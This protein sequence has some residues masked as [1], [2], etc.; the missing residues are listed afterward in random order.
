MHY[1]CQLRTY[2]HSVLN[3]TFFKFHFVMLRWENCQ[4]TFLLCQL[5]PCQTLPVGD[6]SRRMDRKKGQTL[7]YSCRLLQ[8]HT[9]SSQQWWSVPVAVTDSS[10]QFSQRSQKKSQH[11]SSRSPEPINWQPL[12]AELGPSSVVFLLQ[13]Q[14]HKPQLNR[15]L[16]PPSNGSILQISKFSYSG[17][18][19]V[20]P[21][22]QVV[23]ASY[24]EHQPLCEPQC[25][26]SAVLVF[27]YLINNFLYQVYLLK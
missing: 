14:R 5:V 23:G 22:L 21:A 20:L 26:L 15:G 7:S 24:N 8:S 1:L 3:L 2:C 10:L 27:S 12:L 6:V 25:S 16:C 4:S 13:V 9:S 18:L 19:F 11:T 17:L